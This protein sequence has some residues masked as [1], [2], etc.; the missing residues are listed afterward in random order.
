MA[1]AQNPLR[2]LRRENSWVTTL[3]LDLHNLPTNHSNNSS[4]NSSAP[5]SA[6]N[7]R[8]SSLS[9]RSWYDM[10]SENGDENDDSYL[11]EAYM[12]ILMEKRGSM[13]LDSLALESP[14]YP[15]D[16]TLSISS[17]SS[18]PIFTPTSFTNL[19]YSYPRA[20]N[21]KLLSRSGSDVERPTP[22]QTSWTFFFDEGFSKGATSSDYEKTMKKLGTSSTLQEFYAHWNEFNKPIDQLPLYFNLRLFRKAV[23][24]LYEDS[25][26]VNGG[27]FV[28]ILAHH[29]Y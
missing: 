3:K 27:K 4:P 29:N 10:M 16:D 20:D 28:S 13:D 15:D 7:S 21:M 19:D 8:R 2:P 9:A 17:T 22:L 5:P 11:E 12:E 24:P 23:K 26:N 25:Q 14:S 18:A 1:T 6:T